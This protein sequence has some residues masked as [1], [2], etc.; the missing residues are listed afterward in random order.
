VGRAIAGTETTPIVARPFFD[1][2]NNRQDSSL[3]VF[4]GLLNGRAEVSAT[5]FFD[6]ADLSALWTVFHGE[7]WHVMALAGVRYL[8][9]EE[10]VR[11]EERVQ[12]S[13]ASPR[14]GGS[15]IGVTDLFDT[16]NFFYG[17]QLGAKVEWR[18]RRWVVDV[19]AKVALGDSHEVVRTWGQTTVD[20]K[21]LASAG[22]LVLASNTG[23]ATRD[24]FAVVPEVGVN[25]GYQIT[26]SLRLFAGYSFIAWSDVARPG[27]QIDFG[28][29]PNLIPTSATFGASGRPA[30]PTLAVRGTDFWA[31][32]ASFGV[33]WRY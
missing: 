1:V 23:R 31:Q 8:N 17:G 10:D 26:E 3:D 18:R 33:E 5:S 12:V 29:N 19:V 14:F 25:V 30:R 2:V 15:A 32:G 6:G 13:P 16:Q 20:G 22:L 9:L 11:I 28:L 27:D 21:T 7:H 24:A 4:P